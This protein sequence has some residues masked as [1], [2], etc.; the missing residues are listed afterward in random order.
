MTVDGV[1]K[2]G[3]ATLSVWVGE[4]DGK[5]YQVKGACLTTK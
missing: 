2:D 3:K 4:F 5:G 1:D